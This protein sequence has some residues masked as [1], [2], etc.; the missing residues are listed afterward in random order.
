V[1]RR[2]GGAEGASANPRAK[3]PPE[4]KVVALV[5]ARDEEGRIGPCVTALRGFTTE[6][7]VVDDAS[8]DEKPGEARSAGARVLRVERRL[9][10]GRALEG[11][12]RRLGDGDLWLLA[13][14]DLGETADGLEVLVRVVETGAADIAIAT[15]PP[16]RAGG[17]GLVKKAAAQAIRIECGFHATAPLSGQRALTARAMALVRP[18]APGFGVETAMTI[19]AVR[20]G[21]RVV[22][23]PVAG[24]DHRP[25]YRNAPG[26]LHRARQGLDIA[27]AVWPRLFG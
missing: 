25:T 16:T 13:D 12:L 1:S 20:A 22:E 14:G 19:D 5:A 18:L 11:A 27:R 17:F 6:V 7:V 23:V 4:T 21:L 8:T 9:G 26:F 15:F 24:L 2:G 3:A 10:K